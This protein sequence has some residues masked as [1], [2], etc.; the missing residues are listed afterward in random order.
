MKGRK[1]E[2]GLGACIYSKAL[3]KW[4]LGQ[5]QCRDQNTIWSD[6]VISPGIKQ[7]TKGKATNYW[8]IADSSSRD[9]VIDS[10]IDTIRSAVISFF[11]NFE[12]PENIK[13]SL[14]EGTFNGCHG[15]PYQPIEYALCFLNEDIVKEYAISYLKQTMKASRVVEGL[16]DFI[17]VYL[18]MKN[19]GIENY[20]PRSGWAHLIAYYDLK[21]GWGNIAKTVSDQESTIH[22]E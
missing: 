5:P 16:D 21:F 20:N 19:S 11:E 9:S 15:D 4:R 3:S 12:D 13:K 14:R 10:I 1:V 7:I 6:L 8:N 22:S 17:E 2:V 18:T